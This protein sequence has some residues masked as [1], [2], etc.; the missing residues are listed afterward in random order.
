MA[1]RGGNWGVQNHPP[2]PFR[3]YEGP[4]KSC[5]NS[6]RSWKLLNIAEFRTQTSEDVRKRG[7]KILKLPP[8]R[9]CFT[10]AMANKLVVIINSL[11]VPKMKIILPY[12]MFYKRHRNYLLCTVLQLTH[13]PWATLA[14]SA[15]ERSQSSD[16]LHSLNSQKMAAV[17]R[18]NNCFRVEFGELWRQGSKLS[19]ASSQ[20][21]PPHVKITWRNTARM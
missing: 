16:D 13:S 11:K 1:Y 14:L 7:S 3:N 4:P 12:E 8:V 17:T 5:T 2:P 15:T 10:L 6:T 18:L 19:R 20:N 21:I 9:N